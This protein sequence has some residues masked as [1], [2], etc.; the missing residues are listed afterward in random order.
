MGGSELT[1]PDF[2]LRRSMRRLISCQRLAKP[3]PHPPKQSS[4]I[5]RLLRCLHQP[6][7]ANYHALHSVVH[8]MSAHPPILTVITDIGDQ[9]AMAPATLPF[10]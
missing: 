1:L 6:T 9:P 10:P 2:V 7:T 5:P 8:A 4:E 3:A